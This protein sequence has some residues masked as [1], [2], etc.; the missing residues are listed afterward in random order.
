MKH[1]LTGFFANS[2][3]QNTK[4][5]G[6]TSS[7]PLS[8]SQDTS[9]AQR[10]TSLHRASARTLSPHSSTFT[11]ALQMTR[12]DHFM[13]IYLLVFKTDYTW[14][15]PWA[16]FKT[17]PS[18]A[19]GCDWKCLWIGSPLFDVKSSSSLCFGVTSLKHLMRWTDLLQLDV[20]LQKPKFWPL[21]SFL[22]Q[23][24]CVLCTHFCVDLCNQNRW[25]SLKINTKACSLTTCGQM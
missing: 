16:A 13:I 25:S 1:K 10:R 24:S 14:F 9:L 20:W 7:T 22:L 12:S 21:V 11:A 3:N 6:C 4:S 17:H 8:G 5:L 19:V 2:A 15:V 18:N 23:D